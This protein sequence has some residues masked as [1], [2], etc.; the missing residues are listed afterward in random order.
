MSEVLPKDNQLDS[1]RVQE[2]L[3]NDRLVQLGRKKK[4]F[5]I[6]GLIIVLAAGAGFYYFQ[7]TKN[8]QENFFTATVSRP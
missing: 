3:F 4:V 8:K 1:A 6:L 7:Q 2:V 5:A